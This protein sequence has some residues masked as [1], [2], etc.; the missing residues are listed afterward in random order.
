MLSSEFRY[1]FERNRLSI[2][3]S[4]LGRTLGARQVKN[5]LKLQVAVDQI[6]SN[7]RLDP[8]FQ[9]LWLRQFRVCLDKLCS[10]VDTNRA[11]ERELSG[12]IH[13][14]QHLLR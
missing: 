4:L 10:A 14:F 13:L 6:A 2:V 7:R 8:A 9:S 12:L 1:R 3:F 11:S 5:L